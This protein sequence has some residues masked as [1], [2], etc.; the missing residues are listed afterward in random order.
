MN[1]ALFL[2]RD[3]TLIVDVGYPRDPAEVALLPGA[4][5]TLRS[6]ANDWTLVIVSNQSGIARG[7]ITPEQA[8]AVHDRVLAAFA[9]EGVAFAGVYY[10]PHAPDAGCACRKPAPGL[11]LDAAREL[12][13]DL[14]A[15]IMIGDKISDVAAGVA[16]GCGQSIRFGPHTQ[17]LEDDTHVM[18]CEDWPAVQRFV[19]EHCRSVAVAPDGT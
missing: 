4:A 17:A 6:L 8:N 5:D 16:A 13:L 7:L 19:A 14:A 10:C 2:D 15:S 11:L 12:D 9:A 1:R 3:G 18:H